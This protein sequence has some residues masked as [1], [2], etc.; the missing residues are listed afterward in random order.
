M[1]AAED[2]LNHHAPPL[3]SALKNLRRLILETAH[4]TEGVGPIEEALRWGQLS[5]VTTESGSGSTIRIDALRGNPAK[6]AIFFHCQSGLIADFR[7][8]YPGKMQFVGERSIEFSLEQPLPVTELKHC[9]SLALTHHLRK[10]AA[11][12]KRKKQ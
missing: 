3:R 5:F 7:N 10:K 12:T 8:R 9:I 11:K 2:T 1:S 4:E 6:Y